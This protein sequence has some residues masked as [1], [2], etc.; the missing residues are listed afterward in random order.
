MLLN[1]NLDAGTGFDVLRW[2]R[3]EHRFVPTAV[4][5]ASA[6]TKNPA[7]LG[8]EHLN[9]PDRRR[10]SRQFKDRLI[11]R[12]SRYGRTVWRHRLAYGAAEVPV[13]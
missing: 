2:I 4:M 13:E 8:C 12:L 5:T 3:A 6:V 10:A 1:P 7:E 11:R 9:A